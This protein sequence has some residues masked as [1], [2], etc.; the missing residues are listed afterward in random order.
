MEPRILIYNAEQCDP[1]KC[2]AIRLSRMN[3]GKILKTMKQIPRGA[4]VL[5]PISEIAFSPADTAFPRHLMLI[6]VSPGFL[7]GSVLIYM[8][9]FFLTEDFP[10]VNTYS[11]L[12]LMIVAV[13]FA[14]AVTVGS[15]RKDVDIL[16]F[17]ASRR[18]GHTLFNF[19]VT[20]TYGFQA[21]GAYLFIR[22]K[23]NLV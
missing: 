4:V 16:A 9:V 20:F 2:T 6:Y 18:L 3:R 23:R 14:T 12:G 17:H 8:I 19:I 10:K 11:Y 15:I 5:N 7:V 21:L 13:L 1:K 22:N